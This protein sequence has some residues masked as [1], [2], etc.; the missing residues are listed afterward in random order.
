MDALVVVDGRTVAGDDARVSVFDRGFLYGDSVFE[1]LRTYG[2]KPY[3]LKE[4]LERLERSA[5][6]VLIPLDFDPSLLVEEVTSAVRGAGYEESV[7]R[8]VVTRGVMSGLGL[9][10]ELSSRPTRVVIVIPLTP[11]PEATYEDGVAAITYPAQRVADGTQA[12]GAKVGNYLV[13][14]LA[15]DLAKKRGAEEALIVDGRGRV[16]EGATSNLFWVRG[17][18]LLTPPES[19]GILVGI[20]RGRVLKLAAALGIQAEEAMLSADELAQVDELFVC[21]SV[22]EIVPL[23]RIDGAMVGNGRPGATTRRLIAAFRKLTREDP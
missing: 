23:V 22:R 9:D 20:T 11:P 16:V 3:A 17:E 21:S 4:H 8:I 15:R 2:G 5:R 13:A 18:R 10:L 12:S 14:V 1:T 19:L 7:I 6:S